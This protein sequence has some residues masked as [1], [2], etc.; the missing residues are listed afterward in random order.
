MDTGE[1]V[2]HLAGSAQHRLAVPAPLRLAAVEGGATADRHEHVLERRAAGRVRMDVAGGD[3]IDAEM[4]GQVAEQR[5]AP[6]I[7]ACVGALQLDEEAVTPKGLREPG[8]SIGVAQ[9]E[10]VTRAPG[11]A[12]EPLGELRHRLRLDGRGEEHPVL[13]PGRP[14]PRMGC[15]E[16]P[17]QVRVAAVALA[18]ERD[19]GAAGERHLGAGDRPHPGRAG[20]VGER[21]RP[22]QAV[23][24]GEGEGCVAHLRRCPGHLV[25]RRG[26][27][28]EAE[29][30]MRVEFD[31]GDRRHT[32]TCSYSAG[33]DSSSA[34]RALEEPSRGRG[35]SAAG[36]E[37]VVVQ[38]GAGSTLTPARGSLSRPR[39]C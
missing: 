21:Q 3:G 16:D 28:Q 38:P 20:R 14:R 8:G 22:A 18:E 27:V 13:L 34:A 25:G 1:P 39:G 30:R 2:E 6:R 29:R 7:A 17:A 23:V 12:D 19:V 5:I 32:N 26:S 24:V 37:A 10:P 31:V 15:G 36:D 9:A 11:E 35:G 33:P 4:R